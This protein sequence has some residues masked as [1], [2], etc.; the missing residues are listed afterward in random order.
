MNKSLG[1]IEGVTDLGVDAYAIEW[2]AVPC[3]EHKDKPVLLPRFLLL[4]DHL[5][6]IA[7][8]GEEGGGRGVSE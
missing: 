4:K 8:R 5:L 7:V 1:V 6:E 2:Q 3:L